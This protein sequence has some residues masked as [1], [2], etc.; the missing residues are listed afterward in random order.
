MTYKL[1]KDLYIWQLFFAKTTFQKV[2]KLN[3]KILLMDCT[4]KINIYKIPL[5]II[6]GFTFLNITYYI[7]FTFLLA[8][9]VNDY[10]WVLGI[11][12]K[13]YNFLNILD[14]KIIIININPSI[15][16]IIS[17]KFPLTSHLLYF[18][19]MNKNVITNYKKLFEDKELYKKFYGK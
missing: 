16:C 12:K 11:V 4:Y 13:L 6:T 2:L 1:D 14:S 10:Y 19:H 5:C 18:W 3:Y 17:K 15:I 9:T 8:E 7:A